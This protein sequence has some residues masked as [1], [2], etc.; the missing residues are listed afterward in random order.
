MSGTPRHLLVLPSS[1]WRRVLKGG[2][3][4]STSTT[5]VTLGVLDDAY[6]PHRMGHGM[7]FFP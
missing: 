7:C 3:G 5:Q 6:G 1:G 4:F 2:H